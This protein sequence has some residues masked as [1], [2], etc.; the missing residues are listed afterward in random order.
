MILLGIPPSSL[1]GHPDVQKG[2][3][4]KV[5]EKFERDV[6]SGHPDVQKGI[7]TVTSKW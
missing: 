7:K 4:T 5:L 2:I 3:K 1:S 6:A